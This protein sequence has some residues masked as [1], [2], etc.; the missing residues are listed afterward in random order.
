MSQLVGK[1]INGHF[2]S[3][4]SNSSKLSHFSNI[5]SSFDFRWKV[6]NKLFRLVKKFEIE[7]TIV[8]GGFP[9]LL[10][11]KIYHKNKC[12]GPRLES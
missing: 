4:F 7:G 11:G 12:Q 5:I 9:A 6:T 3:G 1:N 8:Y 10:S 2:V